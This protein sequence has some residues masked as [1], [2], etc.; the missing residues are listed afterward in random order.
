M[1]SATGE[2]AGG[3]SGATSGPGCGGLAG[4][5]GVARVGDPRWLGGAVLAVREGC[6]GATSRAG[7]EVA[8]R[9]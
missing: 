7:L 8:A 2:M 9:W 3:C 6:R 4:R 1:G 5:E